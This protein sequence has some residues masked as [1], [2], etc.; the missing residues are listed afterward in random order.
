[1]SSQNVATTE[2]FLTVAEKV[3]DCLVP[4]TKFSKHCPLTKNQLIKG[5]VPEVPKSTGQAIKL[6]WVDNLAI[7][8]IDPD[9]SLSKEEKMKIYKPM[10]DKLTDYQDDCPMSLTAHDGLH[11]YC[12]WNDFD[13]DAYKNNSMVKVEQNAWVK[14]IKREN[15][16]YDVDIFNSS[17]KNVQQLVVY[18]GSKIKD[19]DDDDTLEY[20][21]INGNED[22]EITMSLQ[23]TLEILGFVDDLKTQNPIKQAKP[24]ATTKPI[25]EKEDEDDV[26]PE[27]VERVA[28]NKPSLELFDA[29][30]DCIADPSVEI[31]RQSS[32]KS[33]EEIAIPQLYGNMLWCQSEE[34]TIASAPC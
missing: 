21:W 29:L 25:K 4:L 30:I 22:S 32:A 10:I 26:T 17:N 12:L 1:M 19:D 15:E 8:D 28:A 3:H 9:H 13:V 14:C 6:D 20:Q 27:D 34:I 5:K 7:V 33:S 24:T 2:N 31:H 18:P 16:H 11:I 23:Q